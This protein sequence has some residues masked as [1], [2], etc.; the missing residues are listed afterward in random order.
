MSLV[1]IYLKKILRIRLS[2]MEKIEIKVRKQYVKNTFKQDMKDLFLDKTQKE[3]NV[4]YFLLFSFFSLSL[5]LCGLISSFILEILS[6]ITFVNDNFSILLFFL[7]C[8]IPILFFVKFHIDTKIYEKSFAYHIDLE[9]I[10]E[11]AKYF[12]K[13][14]QENIIKKIVSLICTN[15]DS[16]DFTNFQCYKD[17][18]EDDKAELYNK[19]TPEQNNIVKSIQESIE[20]DEKNIILNK[21]KVH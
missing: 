4:L 21:E 10:T 9:D 5:C 3:K 13:D 7:T 14:K 20:Q 19:L 11:Y 8:L 16:M 2:P 15:R 6:S 17:Y 1:N 18:I 12:K